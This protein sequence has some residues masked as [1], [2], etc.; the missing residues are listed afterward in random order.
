LHRTNDRV[1]AGSDPP[2]GEQ[3]LDAFALGEELD[4]G[5]FQ[6]GLATAS[7]AVSLDSNTVTGSG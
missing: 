4:V 2:A 1:E 6:Q 7:S 5:L 3:I